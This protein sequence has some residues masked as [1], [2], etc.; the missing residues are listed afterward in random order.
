M[1]LLDLD[2]ATLEAERGQMHLLYAD[3]LL[4]RAA[5]EL[6]LRSGAGSEVGAD[7]IGGILGEA[8]ELV[9]RLGYARRRPMLAALQAAAGGDD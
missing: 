3:I 1:A 8:D 4:Q 6:Y 5:C 7:G 9:E 2:R